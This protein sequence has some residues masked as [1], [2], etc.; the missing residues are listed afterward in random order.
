LYRE[1]DEE[2][3]IRL[4]DSIVLI[5]EQASFETPRKPKPTIDKPKIPTPKKSVYIVK[6]GDNLS[7]IAKK[8]GVPLSKLKTLNGNGKLKPGQKIRLK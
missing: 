2:G 7:V 4:E 3:G 8:T 1:A 5:E 6:S